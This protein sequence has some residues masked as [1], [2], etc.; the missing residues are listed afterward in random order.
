M[1][2]ALKRSVFV[3]AIDKLLNAVATKKK[4]NAD[5]I[6]VRCRRVL[7]FKGPIVLSIPHGLLT[8]E[9]V[10]MISDQFG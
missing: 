2:N 8:A 9:G 4:T 1:Y 3:S 7:K 6:A 5:K 10:V